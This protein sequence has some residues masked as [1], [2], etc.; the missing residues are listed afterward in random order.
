VSGL[1]V[2][3]VLEAVGGGTKKQVSLLVEGLRN[4]GVEVALVLPQPRPRDPAYPLMDYE[5]PDEMRRR[6]FAVARFPLGHDILLREDLPTLVALTAFLRRGRFDVIHTHSAKAGALG[7]LAAWLARVPRRVHTPYSLPFRKEL[8]QGA[9]YSVYYAI[10]WGLGRLTDVF[11][12]SSPSEHAEIT[13]SGIAGRASVTTIAN[14]FD[15]ENYPWPPP[16]RAAV[17]ASLGLP[18]AAPVIGTVARLDPQKGLRAL[19]DASVQVIATRPDARFVV[20]G[21]GSER[22]TLEARIEALGVR[23]SWSLVGPRSDYKTWIQAFDVFAFPSLYEGLPFAPMEAMALGAPVV[24]TAAMGT[25]DLVVDGV[26]GLL[27]PLNDMPALAN[28][29]VR[30]LEDDAFSRKLA[31]SARR[32]VEQ[33]FGGDSQIEATL[34][35]YEN[36]RAAVA[37]AGS[38]R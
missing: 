24:A 6:G 9:A 18:P 37:S 8:R 27:V 4:R 28:A 2:V 25:T 31:T 34:R 15:L 16:A 5:F 23:A 26:N 36:G 20:V 13:A 29:L 17:K 22:Q 33:E 1:R 12:A 35:V 3:H 38:T 21:G 7:R 32:F 14:C 11:I 30:I 10:E 19:V